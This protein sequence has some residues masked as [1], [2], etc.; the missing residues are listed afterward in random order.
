MVTPR[1]PDSS[2]SFGIQYGWD[3]PQG[4]GFGVRLDSNFVDD[5]YG[6]AI[7]G[8]TNLIENYTLTNARVTWLSADESWEAAFE[9]SNLTDEVY[10]VNVFD[11]FLSTAG[12]RSAGIA[13]P[14]M[15]AVHLKRNFGF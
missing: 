13:P 12:V 10:Y 6:D 2:W 11:Q 9:V 15:Y 7:N 4:G 5:M 1:T 3:L 14:R 8:P